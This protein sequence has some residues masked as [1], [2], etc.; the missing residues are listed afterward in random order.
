MKTLVKRSTVLISTAAIFV[1]CA[2]SCS[3]AS[4]ATSNCG[5]PTNCASE[6]AGRDAVGSDG[7]SS[8]DG[9]IACPSGKGPAMASLPASNGNSFC[10]D[11]TEVTVEHYAAFIAASAG[12]TIGQ[13]AECSWNMSFGPDTT[14]FGCSASTN[15]VVQHPHDPVRCVDWCDARAYCQ[16]AGKHLCGAVGGSPVAPGDL[17]DVTKSEWYSACTSQGKYPYEYGTGF[18]SGRCVDSSYAG[19]GSQG[20][21]AV[22]TA[23]QCHSPDSPF[24][25]VFDMVG[26]VSEWVDSCSTATG[27]T[28]ICPTLGFDF[29]TNQATCQF[30]MP[31]QKPL[32]FYADTTIGFR[33]CAH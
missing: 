21:V 19:V 29:K 12:N 8:S 32:R 27:Q 13:P 16:W 4:S 20:P 24:A 17:A 2:T 1:A 26:N 25:T 28:D 22:G 6:D 15:D 9:G 5:P 3:S 10:I 7:E 23:R 18:S 31:P 11:T 14:N 30:D 33:C